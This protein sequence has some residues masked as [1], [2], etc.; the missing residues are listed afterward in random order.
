MRILPIGQGKPLGLPYFRPDDPKSH[1]FVDLKL[2]LN[3]IDEI[4][5]LRAEPVLHAIAR[6]LNE[7]GSAFKSTGC[8]RWYDEE[9]RPEGAVNYGSYIGFALDCWAFASQEA[10]LASIERFGRHVESRPVNENSYGRF[11]IRATRWNREGRLGWSLEFWTWGFGADRATAH[12]AWT[13]GI[14]SFGDYLVT[15]N[16]TW[17]AFLA[18]HPSPPNEGSDHPGSSA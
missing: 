4:P 6:K 13:A 9:P 11:E 16:A 10:S 7:Q 18:K 14:K 1:D 17:L 5:E 15:E 2:E 3:R 8:E 12:D